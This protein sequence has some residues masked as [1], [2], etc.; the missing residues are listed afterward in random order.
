MPNFKDYM[1]IQEAADFLGVTVMTLY[2]WDAAGKLSPSRHPINGYR[3]YK[4]SELVRLLK[5]VS[6]KRKKAT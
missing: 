1:M 4:R 2:R 6:Q 3:L 5:K